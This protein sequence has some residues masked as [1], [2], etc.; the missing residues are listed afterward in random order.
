MRFAD[1]R[2]L[3]IFHSP[4]KDLSAL[5]NPACGG[6]FARLRR[7]RRAPCLFPPRVSHARDF[8]RVQARARLLFS[9]AGRKP[10]PAA[11]NSRGCAEHTCGGQF[12]HAPSRRRAV[13]AGSLVTRAEGCGA[14][15]ART[16][17]GQFAHRVCA[18]AQ[19]HTPA[20]LRWASRAP[21]LC[22]CPASH[23]R[24]PAAGKSRTRRPGA[25]LSAQAASSPAHLRWA[26][27]APGLCLRPASHTCGE[28]VA[29]RVCAFAQ[30]RTPARLRRAIRAPGL[31]RPR[32]SHARGCFRV[33]TCTRASVFPNARKTRTP[34]H[35]RR[36]D[37]LCYHITEKGKSP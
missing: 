11:S 15:A 6:Q 12:A 25:G 23:A 14:S 16:C 9:R 3:K 28:Q 20:H 22:L 17:G 2:K 34:A 35:L 33:R 32:V 36:G 27:R 8:F 19:P 4:R 37:Y 18:F 10:A 21:G 7:A 13:C 24:A 5:H 29:H 26:S 1:C 31:F 30:P